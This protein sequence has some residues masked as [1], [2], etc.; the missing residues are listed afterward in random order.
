M[1]FKNYKSVY[2][3]YFNLIDNV[4]QRMVNGEDYDIFNFI[5]FNIYLTVNGMIFFILILN[6]IFTF[7]KS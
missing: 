1:A 5:M 7:F 4:M 2:L 6:I 3:Q